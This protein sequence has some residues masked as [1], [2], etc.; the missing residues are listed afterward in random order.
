MFSEPPIEMVL[1]TNKPPTTELIAFYADLVDDTMVVLATHEGAT[2]TVFYDSGAPV[3]TM[4]VP[5]LID[6]EGDL[7]RVLG[8]D[9]LEIAGP[10]FWC[11]VIVSEIAG[12]T[13]VLIAACVADHL[14][15]TFLVRTMFDAE[16]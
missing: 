8:I 11:E 13:G 1:L 6:Y 5:K 7:C 2:A 15:G 12:K 4:T 3:L 16:D 10:R 14:G 9:E